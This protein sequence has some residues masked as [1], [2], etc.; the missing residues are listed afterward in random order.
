ME[1][2]WSVRDHTATPTGRTWN[3]AGKIDSN[4][5]KKDERVVFR[6]T[7]TWLEG[8]VSRDKMGFLE[9]SEPNK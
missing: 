9:F 5:K 3:R 7:S 1:F 6:D 8:A 2:Q 4:G